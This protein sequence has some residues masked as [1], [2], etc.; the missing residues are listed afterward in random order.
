MKKFIL[1]FLLL[2]PFIVSLTA[3]NQYSVY[4]PIITGTNTFLGVQIINSPELLPNGSYA[5]IP[6]WLNQDTSFPER[7]IPELPTNTPIILG[8]SHS[9]SIWQTNPECECSPPKEEHYL[10]YA[11]LVLEKVNKFQ[12]VIAVG[13]EREPDNW[14][15]ELCDESGHYVNC[16]GQD[17]SGGEAYGRLVSTVRST[18]PPEV[19][20]W[21]G[22]LYWRYDL[23]FIKGLIS[24]GTFDCLSFH[25][26]IRNGDF[27][28]PLRQA[29]IT[30]EL[31][32]KPLC[33]TETSIFYDGVND[34]ETQK[35][36]YMRFILSNS[37]TFKAIIWYTLA[38][39]KWP[40]S[41]PTDLCYDGQCYDAYYIFKEYLNPAL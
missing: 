29:E 28:K 24:T 4:L 27:E 33:L 31:T 13:I 26:Y 15:Y 5:Y 20:V 6:T 37:S 40:W 7:I 23:E 18:L 3:S 39:N 17:F 16:W 11:N 1:I 14:I 8:I 12:N 36:E 2:S 25:S 32:S 30:K 9:P 41:Y 19:E 21:A 10:D 34:F 38:D 35:A 22:E